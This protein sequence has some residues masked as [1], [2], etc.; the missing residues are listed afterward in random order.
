MYRSVIS[1]PPMKRRRVRLGDRLDVGGERLDAD[2]R[3]RFLLARSLLVERH[4]VDAV[5]EALHDER[6]VGD[7]RKNVVGDTVA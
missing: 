3:R 2:A 5:R 6:P 4:P 7:G 1:E